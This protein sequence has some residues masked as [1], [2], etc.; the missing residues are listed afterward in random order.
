MP[1][2]DR[3]AATVK[4]WPVLVIF[5]V[6]VG[7]IYS[8]L[9]TPTEGAAIGAFGTGLAAWFS[10]GLNRKTLLGAVSAAP[11]WPPA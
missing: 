4:V 9:F 8:G 2:K 3:I 7:G 11:R 1:M 5:L 6:V 10:G